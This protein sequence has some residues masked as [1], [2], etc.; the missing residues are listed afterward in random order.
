[1]SDTELKPVWSKN[2]KYDVGQRHIYV[3]HLVSP[4]L[5][6]VR[7]GRVAELIATYN[8]T[9]QE[10]MALAEQLAALDARRN[11]RPAPTERHID[12][13]WSLW[14]RIKSDERRLQRANDMHRDADEI[15]GYIG[16]CLHEK[17]NEIEQLVDEGQC[18][19]IRRLTVS[20]DLATNI[21]SVGG[22]DK[23]YRSDSHA[24]NFLRKLDTDDSYFFTRGIEG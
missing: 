20:V 23:K 22:I 9:D 4:M 5:P 6:S 15:D 21:I 8:L 13:Y 1:M 7:D 18:L 19:P 24:V 12:P 14:G 3:Y 10:Q 2:R 17:A 11:A 16:D